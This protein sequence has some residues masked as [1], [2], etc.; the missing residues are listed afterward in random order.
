MIFPE[1]RKSTLRF[2]LHLI[3]FS[4][5]VKFFFFFIIIISL[6]PFFFVLNNQTDYLLKYRRENTWDFT[7]LYFLFFFSFFLTHFRSQVS[8]KGNFSSRLKS[9]VSVEEDIYICIIYTTYKR[10]VRTARNAF[11]MKYIFHRCSNE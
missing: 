9:Q 10:N 8:F 7:K 5:A 6:Q 4:A 3:V 2:T 11:S 1:E